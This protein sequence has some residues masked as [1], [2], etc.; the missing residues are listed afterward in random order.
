MTKMDDQFSPLKM[1]RFLI[2]WFHEN[3][4][5]SILTG[6]AVPKSTVVVLLNNSCSDSLFCIK[7]ISF[8]HRY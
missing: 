6:T 8:G 5:D 2:F 1:Q 3:G 7:C 4:P